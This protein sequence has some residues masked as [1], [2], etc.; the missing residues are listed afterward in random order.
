MITVIWVLTLAFYLIGFGAM[1][2][3]ERRIPPED[4][5]IPIKLKIID[6]KEAKWIAMAMIVFG[7]AI[8][9][10]MFTTYNSHVIYD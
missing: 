7:V 5:L 6:G 2:F 9:V 4:F 3:S 1:S 8:L 10:V